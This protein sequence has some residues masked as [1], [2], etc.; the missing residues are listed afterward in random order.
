VLAAAITLVLRPDRDGRGW[1]VL[2]LDALLGIVITGLV[3]DLVL[4]SKIHLTGAAWWAT[5]GFHYFSPWWTLLGWVL[6]G[7]RPRVT[8]RTA[9]AAFAWPLAWIAYT[10]VH[11]AVSGWYPYPFLDAA[12]IGYAHALRNTAV[13]FVFAVLLAVMFKLLDR[14][15]AP[16]LARH[17]PGQPG[18]GRTASA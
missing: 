2:R 6:F 8:R 18:H 15:P 12:T 17:Q 16:L 11:G 9:A 1:R 14:L 5:L 7:P 3:F 10:F 4:A 13:V